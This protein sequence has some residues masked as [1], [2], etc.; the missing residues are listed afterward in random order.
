M[1]PS[2]NIVHVG[3]RLILLEKGQF[4]RLVETHLSLQGKPCMFKAGTV[5]ALFPCQMSCFERNISCK[6]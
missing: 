5:T 6:F 1:L 2:N 3:E 4:S